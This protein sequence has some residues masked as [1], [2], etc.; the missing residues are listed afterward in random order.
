MSINQNIM[1]LNPMSHFLIVRSQNRNKNLSG[2]IVISVVTGME[3]KKTGMCC[4]RE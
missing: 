3:Q 4:I 1:R 2:L